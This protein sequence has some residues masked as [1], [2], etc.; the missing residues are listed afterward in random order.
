MNNDGKKIAEK[1]IEIDNV[2]FT[3]WG[4]WEKKKITK[5]VRAKPRCEKRWQQQRKTE[6]EKKVIKVEVNI[7]VESSSR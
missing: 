7:W 5:N 6:R 4:E 3:T 2:C 1:K